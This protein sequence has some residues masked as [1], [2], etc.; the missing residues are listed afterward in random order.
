MVIGAAV[1]LLLTAMVWHTQSPLGWERPIITMVER[2]PIPL[3]DFW[4]AM[5]EPVPFALTTGALGFFAAARG[6]TWLAVA[7]GGGCLVAVFTAE[8]VLKPLVDRVRLEVVGFHHHFAHI[9]GPMFP[10]AHVTA[11]TAW[12]TFAWL[13]LGR[14]SRWRRLLFA[15]P[16]VVGWAVID[17]HMHYPADVVAGAILGSTVVYCS[18]ALGRIAARR[19][20]P[21]LAEPP[22]RPDVVDASF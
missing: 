8:I 20:D 10:S 9:G 2:V 7:G 19:L 21:P 1:F 13:I 16:V 15:L 6:R 14:K 12:A 11:A 22:R 5:F 4:I 17:K 18:V 3:R